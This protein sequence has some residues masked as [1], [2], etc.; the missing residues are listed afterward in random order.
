MWAIV[1][2]KSF[3]G[4]K[5]RLAPVLAPGE[6]AGL[7]AAMLSD[8]LAALAATPG[9]GGVL[10]VAGEAGFAPKGV[11]VLVDREARGQ[12]AAVAQGVRALAAEGVGAMITVP[13]DVP[14]ATPAEIAQVLAHGPGPAVSIAPARDR[15]GTNVLACT[16]SDLIGFSFGV[17]SFDPHC[18]AARA[19]G[20]EP[21][22]LELSGLGL[23]IDTPDDLA[24]LIARAPQGATGRFLAD[25]GIAVRLAGACAS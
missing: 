13:G 2:I 17:A 3:A 4:A 25:A 6:R 16:P 22:V 1:P 5:S 24:A 19:A 23:D 21:R 20:V 18:A 12:S 11:R 10:I 9:L 8:V 7:A 14:L 15:L